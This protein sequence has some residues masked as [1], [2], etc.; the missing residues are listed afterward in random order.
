MGYKRPSGNDVESGGSIIAVQQDVGAIETGR[1]IFNDIG[2]LQ[3][4]CG[5]GDKLKIFLNVRE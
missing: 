2:T 5:E 4:L 1:K 3:L